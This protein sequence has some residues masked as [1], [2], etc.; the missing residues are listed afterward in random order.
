MEILNISKKLPK[1]FE[2]QVHT[3]ADTDETPQSK[4][5]KERKKFYS[6]KERIILLNNSK[7]GYKK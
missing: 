3:R 5:F 4:N 6:L 1:S 7:K 2:K